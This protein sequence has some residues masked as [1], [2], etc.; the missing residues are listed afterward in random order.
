MVR[1]VRFDF[2]VDG[3]RKDIDFTERKSTANHAKSTNS[4]S[5]VSNGSF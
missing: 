3:A 4:I 2:E 5:S 1:A